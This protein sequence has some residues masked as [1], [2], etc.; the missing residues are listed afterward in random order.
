MKFEDL[1]SVNEAMSRTPL[2]NGKMYAE[3]PQRVQAFRK[4]FPNGG[5]ETCLVSDQDGIA[6][7]KAIITDE[8][9]RILATGHAFEDRK[10]SMINNTSYLENA[11][12]SAV[13]RALGFLGIGSES[14]IASAEEVKN[15]IAQQNQ[16]APDT[17]PASAPTPAQK[18][19]NTPASE[20][21][22]AYL[23]D[24]LD[25]KGVSKKKVAAQN[26]VKELS[27]LTADLA[28]KLIKQYSA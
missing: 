5:I 4:L 18:S 14:S 6:T 26:N 7:I 9:G 19:Q 8:N 24:L 28:N 23:S 11:E 22:I 16:S 3:V 10:S 27:E 17:T 21:Q 20:K 1:K 13:G 2:D 12:T 25:K 15:A